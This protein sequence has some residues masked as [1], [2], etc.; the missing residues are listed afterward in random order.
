MGSVLLTAGLPVPAA[1][2]V[3]ASL[4]ESPEK[5]AKAAGDSSA[6]LSL[7]APVAAAST[8][9]LQPQEA[10]ASTISPAAVVS[11]P[12]NR[13]LAGMP[14]T[15]LEQETTSD[16]RGRAL[17]PWFSPAP[18][19]TG[20]TT[21]VPDTSDEPPLEWRDISQGPQFTSVDGLSDVQPDDWAFEAVRS[22]VEDYNCLGGF[23]DGTFRGDQSMTRFQFAAA[24]NAC[25]DQVVDLS[26]EDRATA[27]A[28]QQQFAEELTTRVDE[29]E[30]AV[31]ELR[32]N[33]FS[34][35]T[36]LFGQVILGLQ[37]RNDNDADFFPVDGVAETADPGA[38][39]INLYS[40]AQ[41]F[42]LS[43]LS[44]RDLLF[45]GLQAGEGNS[46]FDAEANR[47]LGLTNNIRLAYEA[48]TD[49][50]VELSDLT[51]RR[52]VGDNLALVA[53]VKGV[54]P[55][56]VFRGPNEYESA[57]AGPL[58]L[59]AQRNPILSIGQGEGGIGFDW[60]ILD[61]LSLQGVYSVAEASNPD[62]GF[63]GGDRTLGFQLT[64][65]PWDSVNLALNY[66]NDYSENGSL[67]TGIGDSQLTAG[68]AITTN[69]F[70]GTVTWDV[71]PRFSI[72]GWGGYTTSVTPGD[73]GS[74]D[75][76]NWMAFLNFPDLLGPGNLGG[77]YVGQPPRITS[78]TLRQGQ[79]IPDLLAG[80][81]GDAGDQPGTTTHL[82]MFF[83]Y[84]VTENISITPGFIA[85]FEP[86]N[87]PDSDTIVIGALRTTFRF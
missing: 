48:D 77:I 13:L 28:L 53:G 81:L 54:S 86:S 33:Q 41:L 60:Q 73:P 78:S 64:A 30:S 6:V 43:Q 62:A 18:T 32:A 24:L 65:T 21:A 12:Q 71:T 70:G 20:P 84:Q 15:D 67:G 25:L 35:T 31:A 36:R 83:R 14:F 66:I 22:L 82:E 87:T 11:R 4:G 38:G 72:G 27:G 23:P 44:R 7:T 47:A 34:S 39:V 79:N 45:I 74:V 29:L 75:T 56:S 16:N 55:V 68:D 80:G 40:N 49:F 17:E 37:G 85:I 61:R 1:I 57:G 8:M 59:F 63:F 10:E 50:N 3:S 19:V 52:L 42:L 9:Q 69:A 2:A 46:L 58:S 76:F 51:Y 5:L 26:P